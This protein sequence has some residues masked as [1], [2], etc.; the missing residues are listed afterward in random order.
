M[1]DILN[2]YGFKRNFENVVVYPISQLAGV[3]GLPLHEVK[4]HYFHCVLDEC[5]SEGELHSEEIVNGE[6]E[7]YLPKAQS[8]I[9]VLFKEKLLTEEQKQFLISTINQRIGYL[10]YQIGFVSCYDMS[11]LGFEIVKR[12]EDLEKRYDIL[13]KLFKESKIDSNVFELARQKIN[14]DMTFIEQNNSSASQKAYNKDLTNILIY[15]NE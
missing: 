12:R 1:I 7:V 14:E 10:E 8:Y 2:G 4:E 3:L 11:Q 6:I 5:M 9:D 15:L 13:E